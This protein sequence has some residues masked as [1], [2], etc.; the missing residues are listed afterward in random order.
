[1]NSLIHLLICFIIKQYLFNNLLS[2][3]YFNNI[4][5]L[6]SFRI[7]QN[8]TKIDDEKL[9]KKLHGKCLTWAN[10]FIFYLVNKKHYKTLYWLVDFGRTSSNTN[11]KLQIHGLCIVLSNG[12]QASSSAG[13]GNGLNMYLNL[14]IYDSILTKGKNSTKKGVEKIVRWQYQDRLK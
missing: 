1:M 7:H 11:P 4:S 8:P 10:F 3:F 14:M 5:S 6:I 12:L 9:L 2:F 13:S